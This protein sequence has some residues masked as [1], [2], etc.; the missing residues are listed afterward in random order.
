MPHNLKRTPRTLAEKA[1]KKVPG[2]TLSSWL[3]KNYTHVTLTTNIVSGGKRLV[4]PQL[5]VELTIALV[6]TDCIGDWSKVARHWA[7]VGV[8]IDKVPMDYYVEKKLLLQQ[9]L[10]KELLLD[11]T[12]RT[13]K[14]F[15]EVLER[16]DAERWA[17][18]KNALSLKATATE[19][20]KDGVNGEQSKTVE[21]NFEIVH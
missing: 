4:V 2:C 8:I 14:K 6:S 16:R 21:F 5:N 3:E 15:L 17:Q 7:P 19:P 10:T 9:L 12:N 18:K 1:E 13:Y 11:D 20:G